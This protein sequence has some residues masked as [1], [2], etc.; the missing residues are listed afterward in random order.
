MVIGLLVSFRVREWARDDG[1]CSRHTGLL[2]LRG[3]AFTKSEKDYRDLVVSPHL[4]SE[5]EDNA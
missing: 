2:H 4:L 5:L 1:C 3:L